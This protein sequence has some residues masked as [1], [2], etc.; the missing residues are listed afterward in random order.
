MKYVILITLVG[1]SLPALANTSSDNVF[2]WFIGV[3]DRID[4]FFEYA[5]SF[6]ERMYSYII[7]YSIKLKLAMMVESMQFAYGVAKELL[8]DLSVYQF[9]DAAFAS[10]DP[11]IKNTIAAYG[12]GSAAMR[13]IEAMTTRFVMDFMGV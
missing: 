7:R 11:D 8:N 2:Q 6:I 4:N 3:A 12:I 13:V 9:I 10:L 5:P 1:L